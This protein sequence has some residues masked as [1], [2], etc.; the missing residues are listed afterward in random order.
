MV[1]RD[2]S[3]QA[4]SVPIDFPSEADHRRQLAIAINRGIKHEAL[5]PTDVPATVSATYTM[6]DSDSMILCKADNAMTIF[7]LTAAG[8]EGRELTV[9]KIDAG[10]R[11]VLVDANGT[12]TI[13]G[14]AVM[15]V[16][17][18]YNFMTIKSDNTNWWIK[19]RG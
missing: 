6:V 16:T 1:I 9:K 8:R 5:H 12:E 18:Q 14:A 19:G 4:Q 15:T 17:A 10:V 3:R 13:D 7:L 11:P 2:V